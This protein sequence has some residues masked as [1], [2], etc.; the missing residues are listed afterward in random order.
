MP[1][2]DIDDLANRLRD[3]ILV[4]L[5]QDGLDSVWQAVESAEADRGGELKM[6]I[7]CGHK[8]RG[9][10]EAGFGTEFYRDI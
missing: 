5:R 2:H 4:R 7:Q 6:L 10:P 1:R 8:K 3:A 9:I